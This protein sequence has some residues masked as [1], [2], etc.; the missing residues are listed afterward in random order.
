MRV[1]IDTETYSEIEL[2][3][4][5]VYRYTEHPSFELLVFAYAIDDGP[6]TVLTDVSLVR[7]LL[8]RWRSTATFVAHNAG[9]DRIVLSRVLGLPFGKYLP[10]EQWD[11][12]AARA[13]EH[14]WPRELA[15]LAV[16]LGVTPKD[17]AG[18]RLINTFSKLQ[19]KGRIRPEDKPEL[20]EEF[21]AYCG[22]DVETLR[23]VDRVLHAWPQRER[24]L[25]NLDQKINDRGILIDVA[26]AEG[27]RDAAQANAA[28]ARREMID[29]T[30]IQN[31]NSNPQLTAWLAD[32]GVHIDNL[33]ARTLDDL[34][35]QPH[36]FSDDVNRVLVLR[37]EIAVASSNKYDAALRGVSRDGR[38]R[39]QFKFHEALTGRWSS[40]GFQV[41]NMPREAFESRDIEHAAIADIKI[42]LGA[43]SQTLKQ[44]VRPTLIINGCVSDF[45]SIEARVLAWLA[46]EQ[47]VLDAFRE[48]RDLYVETAKAMGGLSR[49]QGKIAVLACGYQGA[50]P[51]LNNMGYVADDAQEI[52]DRWRAA[53]PRIVQ[54]W[55]DLESGFRH[56]VDVGRLK[57]IK[58]DRDRYVRLPSGRVLTYR[59]VAA[60]SRLSYAHVQGR[61]DDTYGGKLT[62]NV[63]QAVAR[64]LLADAMIRLDRAG[65]PIV[66]HIHDEVMI[67]HDDVAGVQAVMKTGPSWAAGLPLDASA[68]SLFRYAKT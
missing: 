27:C 29:I 20:F 13:A 45:S 9:F 60:G 8:H 39:G 59:D 38:L 62:E 25:W 49:A 3:K 44:L 33:Q 5:N 2:K 32:Q 12:T 22:N 6:V 15:K 47:W 51:S 1:Y 30:G 35:R 31:P 41:H 19:K 48:G 37:A 58:D 43:S 67:E 7:S 40:K 36:L 11:D 4:S 24:D 23:E 57:I 53:N 52:V 16:A 10:P 28:A 65:Y 64:D 56:G 34:R 63:T 21:K 55:R 18:T 17:S 68:D 61:R 54:F 26:L 50:V 66:G 42:G 14:G 46:G